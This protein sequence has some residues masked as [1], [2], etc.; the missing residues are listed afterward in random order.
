MKMIPSFMV[1]VVLLL[2]FTGCDQQ[3]LFE[4]SYPYAFFCQDD[5]YGKTVCKMT[6]SP[7]IRYSQSEKQSLLYQMDILESSL[8]QAG[9]LADGF[10]SVHMHFALG[11][12]MTIKISETSGVPLLGNWKNFSV[13]SYIGDEFSKVVNK[14]T[15]DDF[16]KNYIVSESIK[17]VDVN[18]VLSFPK[19]ERLRGIVFFTLVNAK[20]I[21]VYA[22]S[23][24][25]GE[26][27]QNYLNGLVK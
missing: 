10:A 26:R 18:Y 5:V 6:A 27:F 4:E 11:A 19:D 3:S 2:M 8:A 9:R 14:E 12:P 22:K 20:S 7:D 24:D 23:A 21:V 17:G 13:Y 25:G 16:S 1:S 15:E